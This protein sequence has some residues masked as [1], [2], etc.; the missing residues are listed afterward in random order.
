MRF[1]WAAVLLDLLFPPRCMG[2]GRRGGWLCQACQADLHPITGDL[3]PQCGHP[4][5][6]D[7]SCPRCR[8]TFN[9]LQ[10]LRAGFLFEGPLREGIHRFKYRGVRALAVPLAAMLLPSFDA[11][12]WSFDVIVPVPLHRARQRGRGYNQ[13]A[14]LAAELANH[15]HIPVVTAAISRTRDTPA[16]VNLSVAERR[17]NVAGAFIGTPG[18]L[19]GQHV[20]LLDDVGTTGSTLEACAVAAREAGATAVWALVLARAK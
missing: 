2:C 3:C 16:Q 15:R 14:L 5:T 4:W 11:L 13:S 17:T 19:A 20:L 1:R 7:G 8:G 10:G 9:A 18:T 12:P 6:G